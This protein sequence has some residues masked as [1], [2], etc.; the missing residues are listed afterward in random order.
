MQRVLSALSWY[1]LYVVFF[2]TSLYCF[3][4][5]SIRDAPNVSTSDRLVSIRLGITGRS[6][7]GD[8][9]DAS[10]LL[11]RSSTV[12]SDSLQIKSQLEKLPTGR[13]LI[14]KKFT[15]TCFR[16]AVL[17]MNLRNRSSV[18]LDGSCMTKS[19]RKERK[20]SLKLKHAP[21]EAQ[22][23]EQCTTL[24]EIFADGFWVNTKNWQPLRCRLSGMLEKEQA[25]PLV[26]HI[27]G[28]SVVRDMFGTFCAGIN[29][30]HGEQFRE[31]G[32]IQRQYCCSEDD[33]M[34]LTY[35]MTWFPRDSFPP[36]NYNAQ[37]GTRQQYCQAAS[38]ASACAAVTPK[39]LFQDEVRHLKVEVWHWLFY[40]SHSDLLGASNETCSQLKTICHEAEKNLVF[41][42]PAIKEDLIP[43]KYAAQRTSRTNARIAALNE[44]L[45]ECIGSNI[46]VNMFVPTH[47]L[48]ETAFA[49]AIH[50]KAAASN[51]VAASI[52]NAFK[53]TKDLLITSEGASTGRAYSHT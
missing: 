53:R 25:S 6:P 32:K 30:T 24:S 47:A 18:Y 44:M 27:A 1:Y 39:I 23:I 33:M 12:Q 38:H 43:H 7:T 17:H 19:T 52:M 4:Q 28:D 14:S 11:L 31:D 40:G 37:Y 34:C 42:T 2:F 50:L 8:R 49:D 10:R 13:Y 16:E 36:R 51:A 46:A 35:R 29:A 3:R 45:P 5:N 20:Y 21:S 22:Y 9:I 26:I 41:G 48:P 15:S